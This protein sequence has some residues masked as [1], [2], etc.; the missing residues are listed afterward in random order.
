MSKKREDLISKRKELMEKCFEC[1][2]WIKGSIIETKRIQGGKKNDFNYLSRSLQGKNKIIYLSKK[3]LEAFK[4]A[5]ILGSKVEKILD[6]IIEINIQI[7][8]LRIKS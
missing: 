6:E 5:R 1:G 7:L 3:N 4:E 2:E 8:K